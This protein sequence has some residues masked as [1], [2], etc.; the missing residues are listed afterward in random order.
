M[1]SG[2]LVLVRESIQT[3]LHESVPIKAT[4]LASMENIIQL[5]R[6]VS[7]SKGRPS[8]VRGLMTPGRHS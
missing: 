7:F 3:R 5:L 6:V 1:G 8:L 2:E 4:V